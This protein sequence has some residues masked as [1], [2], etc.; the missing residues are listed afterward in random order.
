LKPCQFRPLQGC[1]SSHAHT[2]ARTYRELPQWHLHLYGHHFFFAKQYSEPP[3]RDTS[4]GGIL[5]W[6]S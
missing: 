3:I 5:Q 1:G 6:E 2:S 4:S